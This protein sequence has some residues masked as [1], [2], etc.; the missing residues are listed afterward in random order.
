MAMYIGTRSLV[1]ADGPKYDVGGV[2]PD[3]QVRTEHGILESAPYM[4]GHRRKK[5][6]GRERE[7]AKLSK[8][9]DGD[10]VLDR[11]IDV[12]VA[13]AALDMNTSER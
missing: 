10:I 6:T 2:E 1:P 9:S 7:Y 13:M 8:M 4:L 3:I 5:L 11:A 12:L